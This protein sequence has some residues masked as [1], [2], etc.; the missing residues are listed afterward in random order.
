[1]YVALPS[2]STSLHGCMQPC[3]HVSALKNPSPVLINALEGLF[4]QLLRPDTW[5]I[6][7]TIQH[8]PC[9]QR[10]TFDRFHFIYLIILDS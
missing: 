2:I 6:S 5:F 8:V 10:H 1:M 4:E 7:N 3:A 9:V